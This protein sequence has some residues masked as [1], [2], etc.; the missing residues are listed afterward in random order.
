MSNHIQ[1]IMTTMRKL[2]LL[3]AI[4]T[5][6]SFV[7][8]NNAKTTEQPEE[9]AIENAEVALEEAVAAVDSAT[10]VVEEAA[11]ALTETVD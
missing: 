5:T 1:H 2:I 6:I 8:C 11:E 9:V 4:A 3:V 10:L 7:A